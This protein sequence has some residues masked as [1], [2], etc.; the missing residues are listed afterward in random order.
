MQ[1]WDP[2]W[3]PMPLPFDFGTTME[4]ME[5]CDELTTLQLRIIN[6]TPVELND[7]TVSG[8]NW[9]AVGNGGVVLTRADEDSDGDGYAD[10]RFWS[11]QNSRTNEDM[12]AVTVQC[13]WVRF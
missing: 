2:D 10:A 9:V 6:P 5:E 4:P 13:H 1:A 3:C 12:L 11:K 8:N 7:L